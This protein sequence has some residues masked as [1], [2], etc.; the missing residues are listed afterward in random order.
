MLIGKLY[1]YKLKSKWFYYTYLLIYLIPLVEIH[2]FV[3]D[4]VY[5]Y[6]GV[7]N[8]EYAKCSCL[9]KDFFNTNLT[10]ETSFLLLL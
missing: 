8:N 3:A 5:V 10:L 4:P 6:V 2:L 1:V 7:N 9:L